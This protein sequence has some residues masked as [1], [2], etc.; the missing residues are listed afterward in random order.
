MPRH[1][2][3]LKGGCQRDELFSTTPSRRASGPSTGVAPAQQRIDHQ[4]G[5]P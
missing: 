2:Q 3:V 1:G 4:V 5:A